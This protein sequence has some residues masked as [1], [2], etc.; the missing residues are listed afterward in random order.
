[1]S[2]KQR[3]K[4]REILD[5][6][7]KY[8]QPHP[9]NQVISTVKQQSGEGKGWFWGVL[10]IVIIAQIIFT[11]NSTD[12]I[13]YEELAESVRNVFWLQNHTLYD[14]VSSN[15]GWYGSLLIVY[16]LFGFS[17]NTAKFVRLFLAII[18]LICIALSLT[19]PY[20]FT[21]NRPLPNSTI[22]EHHATLTWN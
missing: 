8:H 5:S 17:L 20:S 13:R 15:I 11:L 2:K 22:H 16:K 12:Q 6:T 7:P 3:L 19:N 18:A 1:M 4:R 14:G 21:S 9:V 10:A